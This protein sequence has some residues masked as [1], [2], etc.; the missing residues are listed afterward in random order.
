MINFPK[1]QKK[2]IKFQNI[3][4]NLPL[5]VYLDEDD[6]RP[7]PSLEDDEEE[8]KLESEKLLLKEQS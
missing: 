5:D 4:E 2:R 3:P 6:L 1:A 8:L 7:M